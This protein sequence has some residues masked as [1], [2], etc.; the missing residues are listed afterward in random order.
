MEMTMTR[1]N[2]LLMA[3]ALALSLSP[4]CGG[5]PAGDITIDRAEPPSEAPSTPLAL[6]L[7]AITAHGGVQVRDEHGAWTAL[8][9]ATTGVTAIRAGGRGAII[10][11]GDTASTRATLWLRGGTEATLSQ[12]DDDAVYVDLSVGQLRMSLLDRSLVAYVHTASRMVDVSARDI[13]ARRD[14]RDGDVHLAFTAASPARAAWSLEIDTPRTEVA[15]FG[16]L[17]TRAGGEM[18]S[19]EL[20]DLRIDVRTHG[21]H[22]VTEV[23]H[24]FHNPTDAQ[25]EGTFRFPLPDGAMLLGL[26]MEI[27]GRMMEGEIVEKARAREIYEKIVDEM[28]DPAL[29]EW[30]HGKWF[31]LRVF[32]IEPVADKRVV[33]RYATPLVPTIGGFEY[34]YATAAPDM[35]AVIESFGLT[36]DGVEITRT[37]SFAAGTD[38]VVP[39]ATADVPRVTRETRADGVYTAV[40]VTPDWS[41]WT[42]DDAP[43]AASGDRYMIVLF[44]TSR[45]ALEG[46]ALALD[47]LR[48]LLAELADDDHVAV[49]SVDIATT[50]ATDGFVAATD[51]AASAAVSSIAGIEPDGASNLASAFDAVAQLRATAVDAGAD[52]VQVVYIGDGTAT[53]G[54]TDTAKLRELADAS[55]G[56][57]ELYAEIIG[58]G[59]SADVWRQLTGNLSGN[60]SLPRTELDARR[61]AFFLARAPGVDRLQRVTLDAG[62][63]ALLFPTEA[64][65]LFRGDS[66]AA[67]LR[68][69]PGTAAPESITLR[70]MLGDQQVEQVYSLSDP[71]AA[72]LVS[73]RWATRQMAKL[74]ADGAD[75]EVIVAMS[76]DFGVMSKHTSLL[77]LE[78]EEA[79]REHEIERRHKELALENAD[80]TVTGGDLDSLSGRTASLSP[81]YIQP[82]DPEIRVPAPADARSVVVVFP[83]GD[84]KIAQFDD[85]ADAWIVRFLIDKD[86]PDGAYEVVVRVTHADGTL[87]TL[88][89]PYYVDTEAPAL[90]FEVTEL[91]DG[92]YRLT[93][94]QI[95]SELEMSDGNSA[96]VVMDANRVEVVAPDGE[97][98]TLRDKGDGVFRRTWR[99]KTALDG[100]VTLRVVVTDKALNQTSFDVAFTPEAL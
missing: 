63:G 99:P 54:E 58:K 60:V 17:E 5:Q 26:S 96:R 69:P 45:S 13:I 39:L 29:L 34:V 19:L 47:S 41:E 12:G 93:G 71:A 6:P 100:P 32:P 88:R 62:D 40:R 87:Q 75:K 61:A 25:I 77:V 73:Q 9:G 72:K 35:Q 14:G 10:G 67:V 27:N 66:I 57:G 89:L 16:R 70:G 18:Q 43:P 81:D 7:R 90:D 3:S 48:L 46:H 21:D 59:A 31:K 68:T 53:W 85:D 80:P 91:S 55:V 23:T 20:R 82:G 98:V 33:I 95:V 97:I 74:E 44:D 92:R 50:L 4:S 42:D 83:F 49:A 24:T 11:L 94:T 37:D 51:D 56:A 22:A 76:V 79:Y 84:T 52:H 30:E 28:L 64:T 2:A 38:V 65:T 1:T 78:S 15:G 36:F 86:T 8:D